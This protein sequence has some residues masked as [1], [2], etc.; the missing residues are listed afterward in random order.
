MDDVVA[1]FQEG[2]GCKVAF[3]RLTRD[4]N[5][6]RLTGTAFVEFE[7]EADAL[8]YVGVGVGGPVG[9]GGFRLVFLLHARTRS[10]PRSLVF[11][12]PTATHRRLESG[13]DKLVVLGGKPLKLKVCKYKKRGEKKAACAL[14]KAKEAAHV[15]MTGLKRKMSEESGE[16]EGVRACHVRNACHACRGWGVAVVVIDI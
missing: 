6:K 12:S 2:A 10:H 11:L 8:K 9:G 13:W 3:V 5:T 4:R 16:P 14:Q 15:V 7:S 1:L